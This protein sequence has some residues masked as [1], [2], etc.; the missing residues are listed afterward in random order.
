MP[1][2]AQLEWLQPQLEERWPVTAS[3]TSRRINVENED[4]PRVGGGAPLS[5]P[6]DLPLLLFWR[7]GDSSR[8][9]PHPDQ[10]ECVGHDS[11]LP[12]ATDPG[13]REV[14]WKGLK[15]PMR[16]PENPASLPLPPMPVSQ[17]RV[18][19]N[20]PTLG[21]WKLDAPNHHPG[22]YAVCGP[23]ASS[24]H[25]SL[26][27]SNHSPLQRDQNDARTSLWRIFFF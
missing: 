20:A 18:C 27:S 16:S 15:A 1:L 12:Q 2:G 14:S 8:I 19:L 17:K 25:C 10:M 11:P 7:N 4:S 6:M 3:C 13:G 26:I 24:S 22:S 9:C 5:C 21:L 23:A